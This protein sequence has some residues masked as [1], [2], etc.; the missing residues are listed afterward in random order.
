MSRQQPGAPPVG[1]PQK[2]KA[3]MQARTNLP[4]APTSVYIGDSYEETAARNQMNFPARVI[5]PM[6]E[7]DTKMQQVQ[8]L[9]EAGLIS[10]ATPYP[11]GDELIEYY[12]TKQ[13]QEELAVFDA[14]FENR[15]SKMTDVELEKAKQV[16][17]DWFARRAA[18]IKE[19]VNDELDY[20]MLKLNGIQSIE[21][22]Y[23]EYAVETGRKKLPKG[24]VYNP[25][26]W[27]L[28]E[29]GLTPASARAMPI[30]DMSKQLGKKAIESYEAGLF[31]PW[32][33]VTAAN[34]P[35]GQNQYLPVDPSGNPN[36]R[37]KGPFGVLGAWTNNLADLYGTRDLNIKRR[38]QLNR[39]DD[40]GYAN[41]DNYAKQTKA[42]INHQY[43][44]QFS[45]NYESS[46]DDDNNKPQDS[47]GRF[48]GFSNPNTAW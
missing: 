46:H 26:E 33:S 20:A 29:A 11:R 9:V 18:V 7:A 23:F 40:P 37:G 31:A 48:R 24:P 22:L 47:G 12:A 45:S 38:N 19:A 30:V 32:K 39:A 14:W 13:A 25:W 2:L 42:L 27:N 5:N 4:Y 43:E 41:A 1:A 44:T 28:R 8:D 35:F 21:D 17:P 3:E 16:Y 36:T 15:I 34:A 6:P 10:S